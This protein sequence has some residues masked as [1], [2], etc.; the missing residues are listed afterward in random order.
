MMASLDKV[1]NCSLITFRCYGG[2]RVSVI[3]GTFGTV[4][5][6]CVTGGVGCS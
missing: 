3:V 1:R 5:E 2:G 6:K 4:R